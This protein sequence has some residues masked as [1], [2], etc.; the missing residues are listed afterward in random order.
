LEA[1]FVSEFQ[2]KIEE[3]VA[4][5][6]EAQKAFLVDLH[7]G[8][9]ENQ[10]TIQLFVDS[11]TGITINEC[12]VLSR[13]LGT[14]LELENTID[15]PYVL[16]VSSPGA[17]RPLKQLRQYQ[18]HVGRKLRIRFTDAGMEKE[19]TGKLIAIEEENIILVDE[20]EKK[21]II[22]FNTIT[23]STVELPW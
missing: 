10:K 20:K 8:F 17:T 14:Q 3:F 2:Q 15:G 21:S 18:K 13:Q 6:L 4:P 16:Q 19:V 11:D 9:S 22:K 23:E 5:L 7:I 1:V 12:A